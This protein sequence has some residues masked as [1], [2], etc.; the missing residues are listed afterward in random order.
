[1]NRV[2]IQ[3]GDERQLVCYWFQQRGR[4][5]TNESLVTFFIF[6]DALTRN[7]TDGA[8]VRLTTVLR[9]GQDREHADGR[10]RDFAANLGG[11]LGRFVPQ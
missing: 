7:R 9:P 6:W 4:V 5:I 10:L 2:E 1:V 11:Q 8:Q 3:N